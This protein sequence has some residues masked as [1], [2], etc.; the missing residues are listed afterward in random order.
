MAFQTKDF[1]SI[2]A[3][4]LNQ[5]RGS[6]DKIT[7]F[8]VGS[9]ARTLIE[10]PAVEIEQLYQQMFIGLREAIPVSTFLSFGF[11][12]LAA[13][14]AHGVV[15]LTRQATITTP[16]TIPQGTEFTA[17]DGR[18]YTSTGDVM[19]V[20]MT[21]TVD[22][23]VQASVTGSAGN[24]AA[25][26][27][28]SS[29]FTASLPYTV[30]ISNMPITNG[31]DEETDAEREARFAAYVQSIS[32]GT[33]MAVL[34]AAKQ[35][36]IV[37]ANGV[38]EEYVARTGIDDQSGYVR[39]YLYSS[40]GLPSAALLADG[41]RLIDGYRDA[42]GN[43]VSGYR[44]A[45]VRIDVL[46][47]IE[48]PVDFS[49]TVS[50]FPGYTL[51]TATQNALLDVFTEVVSSVETGGT[52]FIGTLVEQL[53]SVPGVRQVVPTNNANILC[54]QNEVLVPGVFSVTP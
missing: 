15:R 10:G 37:G 32:R 11:T 41:Q 14:R 52:L 49:A 18:R 4:A 3:G 33:V 47:M 22:V 43:P 13:S 23:P 16:Q 46:P 9:V 53:L 34:Y 5:M 45:G 31:R 54:A 39:I 38:V 6:T 24:V 27:I 26:V 36:Q 2:V 51:N 35:A 29:A 48:A 42:Q 7:D 30:S 50:M 25:G 20:P 17:T 8:R 12:P 28:T 19:W 21:A 1:I 40:I 44:A